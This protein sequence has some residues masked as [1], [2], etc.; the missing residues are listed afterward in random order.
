VFEKE[1][2]EKQA[3][4]IP[5]KPVLE[6]LHV[7]KNL[8]RGREGGK[9]KGACEKQKNSTWGVTPA[10]TKT[11]TFPHNVGQKVI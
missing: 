6:A 4:P 5:F 8:K 1:L 10:D 7:Q 11:K 2:K 3:I 9:G